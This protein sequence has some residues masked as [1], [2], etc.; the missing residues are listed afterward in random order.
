MINTKRK[1]CNGNSHVTATLG[2]WWTPKDCQG[3]L[4]SIHNSLRFLGEISQAGQ[5]SL[6]LW[7]ITSYP[8]QRKAQKNHS[9]SFAVSIALSCRLSQDIFAIFFPPSHVHYHLRWMV[10]SYTDDVFLQSQ[11]PARHFSIQLNVHPQDQKW[12]NTNQRQLIMR[13]SIRRSIN[14]QN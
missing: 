10:S 4:P 8:E 14:L 12:R 5:K 9:V 6:C 11:E 3:V 7:E 1:R 2:Q 13:L